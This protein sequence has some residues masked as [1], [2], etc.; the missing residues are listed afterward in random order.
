MRGGIWWWTKIR[1]SA[2][3]AVYKYHVHAIHTVST[4]MFKKLILLDPN[5]YMQMNVKWGIFCKFNDSSIQ[6]KNI[7]Y[8]RYTYTESFSGTPTDTLHSTST[9][10]IVHDFFSKTA[11]YVLAVSMS[12]YEGRRR[13]FLNCN[14]PWNYKNIKNYIR[15]CIDL[16]ADL[17]YEL[18]CIN[19]YWRRNSLNYNSCGCVWCY[20]TI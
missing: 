7:T 10:R 2:V 11:I 18:I 17:L 4:D 1:P 6:G 5:A 12:D 14:Y 19:N 3:N 8:T 15:D 9:N 16:A 20:I 13:N